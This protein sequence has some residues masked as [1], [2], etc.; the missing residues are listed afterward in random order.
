VPGV[1]AVDAGTGALAREWKPPLRA[2]YCIGC[3]EVG[4]LAAGDARIFAAVPSAV[5]ALDPRTGAVDRD[6]GARIGL[7]AGIYGGA[8]VTAMARAGRRLYITGSFDSVNGTRR[9]AFAAVDEAT[10]NVLPSWTPT[11][12]DGYGSV[13]V[14]SGS[15]VLLGIQLTQAVRFDIGGMEAANQPFKDLK[16]LLALSGPGSVRIGLGRRCDF[17][18]WSET[19]RCGGRV[20]DWLGSVAFVRAGRKK[21]HHA[22]PGPPGRYFVRFVPSPRGGEPQAPY[23]IAFRHD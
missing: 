6:W 11:A 5:H 19:G 2:P 1:A 22:I 4:A 12:N 14:R 23:D 18:R 15:R 3:T 20:T 17:E 7:T 9:L 21:F 8:G 13:V 16:V 10:G